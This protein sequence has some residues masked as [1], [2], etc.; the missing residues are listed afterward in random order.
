MGFVQTLYKYRNDLSEAVLKNNI[1][2]ADVLGMIILDKETV[3]Y[4]KIEDI[5]VSKIARYFGGGGHKAAASHPKDNEK[6]VKVLKSL[7]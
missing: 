1:N 4:R 6:F 5:D 7:L 3:S 2:D